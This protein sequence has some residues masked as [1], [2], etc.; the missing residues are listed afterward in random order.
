[1]TE[2]QE[3]KKNDNGEKAAGNK[4][5]R[6]VLPWV[7]FGATAVGF[8]AYAFAQDGNGPAAG[9]GG[10]VGSEAVAKVD[11]ETITA[12]ELYDFLVSQGGAQAV[13]QLITER[14]VDNAAKK[15]NIKVTDEELNA[16]VD[17]IKEQMGGQEAFDQAL[18]QYGLTVDKLK[19][20][21]VT[22]VQLTKLLAPQIK[23]TDEDLKKY[24]DEN[25]EQFSTPEQV[26]ASHILVE[27]KE[28]AEAI[29]KQLKEGADFA[30]LAEE[31]SK[32]PGSAA[33]GGDLDFFG[34]GQMMPEFEEAAFKTPV[35]ELSGI[36]ET[37]Y[38]FHIIKVTDK[39]EAKTPT[40]DEKK[41]EIR[42]TLVQQQTNEKSQA[43][44]EELRSKAKIENYLQQA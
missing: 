38:G 12:N 14:L 33:K 6:T 5:L 9:G 24:Y 20:Q 29:V 31:K 39:K 11:D 25:K 23:I 21:L 8:A 28:E 2:H 17:K 18:V 15:S 32:D 26:R 22:Q 13:D 34:K 43:Y 19:E 37:D 44:I 10:N 27:T 40:F 30:E 41:E 3:T 42:E 16:E 1:M 36:V 7:L 4:V 35:G